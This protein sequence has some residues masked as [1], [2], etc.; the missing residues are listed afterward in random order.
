MKYSSKGCWRRKW[1]GYR[2]ELQGRG[3]WAV[4]PREGRVIPEKRK[5]KSKVHLITAPCHWD[6]LG[7]TPA[8]Q[9]S[10][11]ERFGRWD[12]VTNSFFFCESQASKLVGAIEKWWHFSLLLGILH[13][14]LWA[15]PVF[16]AHFHPPG[17]RGGDVITIPFCIC[18]NWGA[19]RAGQCQVAWPGLAPNHACTG[20][21]E[22]LDS[23]LTGTFRTL[24]PGLGVWSFWERLSPRLGQ[25]L[26][27]RACNGV[28][29]GQITSCPWVV[30]KT[31][32]SP[33]VRQRVTKTRLRTPEDKSPS[34]TPSKVTTFLAASSTVG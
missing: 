21:Q 9:V 32:C 3:Q 30:W 4:F 26:W 11:H 23:G 34:Q 1:S 31:S 14:M 22:L 8:K 19:E 25:H 12:L 10:Q 7:P 16:Q 33:S 2:G 5:R 20:L 13:A 6:G 29:M 17:N 24:T 15:L 18:W 27:Q 28:R